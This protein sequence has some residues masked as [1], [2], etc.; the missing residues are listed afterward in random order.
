[1]VGVGA[2]CRGA[3]PSRPSAPRA[4]GPGPDEPGANGPGANGPGPDEPGANGPGPDGGVPRGD[5]PP[6]SGPYPRCRQ[7]SLTATPYLLAPEPF[8]PAPRTLRGS[9]PKP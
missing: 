5:G 2:R 3:G 8:G 6:G 1:H 7:A 4:N 9:R